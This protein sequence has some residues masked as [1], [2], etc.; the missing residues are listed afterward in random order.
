[1]QGSENGRVVTIATTGTLTK[2]TEKIVIKESRTRR[3]W[4]HYFEMIDIL[5]QFIKAERTGDW[6]LHLQSLYSMLP[7]FAASG[8]DL[9]AKS[10]YVFLTPWIK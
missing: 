6:E 3:L 5:K 7:Y 4:L 1:M 2:E 8:R 10:G 9:Y